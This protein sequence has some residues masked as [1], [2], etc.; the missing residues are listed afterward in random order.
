MEIINKNNKNKNSENLSQKNK[1][2]QNYP[3]ST[4]N[5]QCVG[6]CYYPDTTVVHPITLNYVNN[7]D[8]AFCPIYIEEL[9]KNGN[10]IVIETGKCNIPTEKFDISNKNTEYNLLIP[11]IDLNAEYFLK[12]YYNIYT[13]EQMLDWLNNMKYTPIKTRSRVVDSAWVVF[14]KSLDILDQRIVDFYLEIIKRKW[15]YE[16]MIELDTYINVDKDNKIYFSGKVSNDNKN[17]YVT[18]KINFLI[19]KFVTHDDVYKF[20]LKYLKYRKES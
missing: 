13:F 8:Y 10:K 19:E 11:H 4:D 2:S 9:D 12:K 20:L 1:E 7:K 15:I 17:K 6:P 16:I 14:G 5:K 3:K 18:E